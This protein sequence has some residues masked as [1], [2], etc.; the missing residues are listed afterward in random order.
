M[1]LLTFALCS[2]ESGFESTAWEPLQSW[3]WVQ[4]QSPKGTTWVSSSHSLSTLKGISSPCSY[5][6]T[7][8]DSVKN[9]EVQQGKFTVV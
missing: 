3:S 6:K 1:V 2:M 7:R 4:K 9:Y 5:A 8:S